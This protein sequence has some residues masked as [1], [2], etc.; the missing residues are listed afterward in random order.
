MI[1]VEMGILST[2][3]YLLFVR[4]GQHGPLGSYKMCKQA[5]R[6]LRTALTFCEPAAI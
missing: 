6:A 5:D 1:L 3:K 2:N 4:G